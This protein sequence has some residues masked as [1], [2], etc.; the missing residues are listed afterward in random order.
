MN[1]PQ[2]KDFDN[3]EK[4]LQEL[5]I[6][7]SKNGDGRLT[8]CTQTEPLFCFVRDTQEE[9]NT[10]VV[11]TLSSYIRSFY[12]VEDVQVNAVSVPLE[13]PTIPHRHL[14]PVSRIRPTFAADG[15]G[16]LQ[17]A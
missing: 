10:V 17:L 4:C 13:R 11:D 9:I 6:T 15:I 16:R 8:V 2:S 5:E 3:L 1:I 14:R 7:V 12:Q